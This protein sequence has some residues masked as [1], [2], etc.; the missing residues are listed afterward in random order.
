MRW[1]SHPAHARANPGA[2]AEPKPRRPPPGP[3]RCD[4]S[5]S[6]LSFDPIHRYLALSDFRL[7][8]NAVLNRNDLPPAPRWP[9]APARWAR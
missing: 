3:G 4:S 8:W 6:R 7:V 5:P 9:L 1:C 2:R